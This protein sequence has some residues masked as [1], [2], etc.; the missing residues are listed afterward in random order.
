MAHTS[1]VKI[2]ACFRN[3]AGYIA[4]CQDLLQDLAI[5]CSQVVNADANFITTGRASACL[6]I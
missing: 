2:M 6:E 5:I 3:A 1:A 4:V